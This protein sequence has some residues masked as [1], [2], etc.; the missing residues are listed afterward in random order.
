MRSQK[1]KENEQY[2]GEKHEAGDRKRENGNGGR[3][4]RRE[5]RE[6]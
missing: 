2:E 5:E 4:G 1:K 3:R 6:R